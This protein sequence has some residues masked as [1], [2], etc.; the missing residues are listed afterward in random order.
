[1]ETKLHHPPH[2]YL[3]DT[4]YFLT[5]RTYKKEKTINT[6]QKKKILLKNLWSEFCKAGYKIYAWT[7]LD[8]H[9]HIQFITRRG[10]DLGEMLNLIHGKTSFEIN[11]IDNIKGRKIFQNYW[12]RCPRNEKDFYS[13][14]NY[15]HHNLVK[16]GYVKTQDDVLKYPFCSYQQWMK[17][18]GE[19]WMSDC[20]AEYP[21]LDFTVDGDE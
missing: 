19:E 14:F 2:V 20:F 10:K 3:D 13:H 7:V 8:N 15:I 21:I 9:Y 6:D 4:I 11:K 12:D 18:K 5:A 1:V 17:K 16:H